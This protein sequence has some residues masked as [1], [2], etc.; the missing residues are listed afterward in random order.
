MATDT[1]TSTDSGPEFDLSEV[2]DHWTVIHDPKG[3]DTDAY[4]LH[5]HGDP[6]LP[7]PTS[8]V[9]ALSPNDPES[10]SDQW[11]IE[12]QDTDADGTV[13]G[14]LNPLALRETVESLTDVYTRLVEYSHE[15]PIA[16]PE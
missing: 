15:Y 4:E 14:Y 11:I 10:G 2:P 1:Q 16:N 3:I 7:E 5:Y 8:A 13:G 12:I 6:D 9:R